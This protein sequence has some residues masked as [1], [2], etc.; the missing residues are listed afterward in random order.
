MHRVLRGDLKKV[1][2]IEAESQNQEPM[3]YT[4]IKKCR[5]ST[6]RLPRLPKTVLNDFMQAK[7]LSAE[8]MQKFEE[9]NLTRPV[10]KNFYLIC[11]FFFNLSFLKF[12]KISIGIAFGGIVKKMQASKSFII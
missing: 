2:D 11:T 6:R 1:E 8:A 12:R 5:E 10:I 4:D 7:K 9:M 3:T